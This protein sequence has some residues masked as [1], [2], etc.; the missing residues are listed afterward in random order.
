M[1]RRGRHEALPCDV[2]KDLLSIVSNPMKFML[3]PSSR[4]RTVV[5]PVPVA[6]RD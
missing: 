6:E 3:W 4:S 2:V 5:G 1:R